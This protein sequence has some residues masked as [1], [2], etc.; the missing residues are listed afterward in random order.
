MDDRI[1]TLEQ[2][3]EEIE[4]QPDFGPA[5][6]ATDADETWEVDVGAVNSPLRCEG[7]EVDKS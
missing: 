3:K 4:F 1:V 7:I 2:L 5:E 6:G